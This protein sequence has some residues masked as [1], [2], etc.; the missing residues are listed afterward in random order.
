M[1]WNLFL[2][3]LCDSVG[4]VHYQYLEKRSS[5][6]IL[7]VCEKL[8]EVMHVLVQLL[9][10]IELS[11]LSVSCASQ[12]TPIPILHI[13]WTVSQHWSWISG[14]LLLSQLLGSPH[15]GWSGKTYINVLVKTWYKYCTG[16]WTLE[17][18]CV[19]W[20]WSQPFQ[21]LYNYILNCYNVPTQMVD[22][23]HGSTYAQCANLSLR[24]MNRSV[25]WLL[26]VWYVVEEDSGYHRTDI[27]CVWLLLLH[28]HLAGF[29]SH[30]LFLMSL[31]STLISIA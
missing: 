26:E 6:S 3:H 18:N 22:S 9:I 24:Q 27:R 17:H 21:D 30:W 2:H 8:Y 23:A 25:K 1:H 31:Y 16:H 20:P 5:I 13:Y 10:P 12:Q 14:H 4:C 7:S 29:G 11:V 15:E 28:G 19:L